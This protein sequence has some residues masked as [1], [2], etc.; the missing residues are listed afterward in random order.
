MKRKFTERLRADKSNI[1]D[2]NHS[3]IHGLSS[4]QLLHFEPI[5]PYS[6]SSFDLSSRSDWLWCIIL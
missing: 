2:L 6:A 3:T 5:H 1:P 4:I